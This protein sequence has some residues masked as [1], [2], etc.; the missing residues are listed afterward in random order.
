MT[1]AFHYWAIAFCIIGYAYEFTL[2]YNLAAGLLFGM[3]LAH[4]EEYRIRKKTIRGNLE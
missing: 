2:F 3:G 1:K 4:Y